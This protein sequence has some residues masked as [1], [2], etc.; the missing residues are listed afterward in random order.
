MRCNFGFD[1]ADTLETAEI[2]L[3]YPEGQ[4]T[5]LALYLAIVAGCRP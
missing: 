1:R 3:S 5:G 2:R 4:F